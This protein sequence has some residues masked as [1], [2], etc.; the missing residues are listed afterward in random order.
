M[1]STGVHVPPTS[2]VI[3]AVATTVI[4]ALIVDTGVAL[5]TK[6]LDSNGTRI[7]LMPVAYGPLTALG[8][9]AGTVGWAVVRRRTTRPRAVL[10]VLVPAVVAVSL[11]PGGILLAVGD[12]PGNVGGLWVMHLVVAVLTVAMAGRVLPLPDNSP[13]R[14]HGIGVRAGL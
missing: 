12:S 10:R 7:G 8:V 6:S 2:R 1:D 4:V 3:V 9:I 11:V 13:A 5:A 14:R